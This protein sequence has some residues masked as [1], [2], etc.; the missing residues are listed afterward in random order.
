ST[1][2]PARPSRKHRSSAM[3]GS[4]SARSTR[5]GMPGSPS[6]SGPPDPVAGSLG[7]NAAPVSPQPPPRVSRGF[8]LPS[9]PRRRESP[10][11]PR[12][13]PAFAGMTVA[14]GP[15]ERRDGGQARAVNGESG[16]ASGIVLD[17][18]RLL[19]AVGAGG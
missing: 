3:F 19:G 4:S 11:V 14:W 10:A 9:F 2:N 6:P 18:D 1:S 7:H 17:G 5:F 16:A 12:E 8:D 13:I 15:Q